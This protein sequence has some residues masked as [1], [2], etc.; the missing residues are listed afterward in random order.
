MQLQRLQ[1]VGDQ[2]DALPRARLPQCLE[3]RKT[4][5]QRMQPKLLR[6]Q[7]GPF[8]ALWEMPEETMIG[9]Q[10]ELATWMR[11]QNDRLHIRAVVMLP[12][13]SARRR[14]FDQSLG[15]IE[16]V[17]NT[18]RRTSSMGVNYIHMQNRMR[19]AV[20]MDPGEAP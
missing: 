10:N 18:N 20:T 6:T 4:P 12:D 5:V 8:W 1:P 14:L 3:R 11:Q 2:R 16:E 7:A 15:L 13:T 9:L 17:L 19:I